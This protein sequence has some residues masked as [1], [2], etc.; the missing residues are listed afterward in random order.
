[1]KT[2][3]AVL[4]LCI[5]SLIPVKAFAIFDGG[6]YVGYSFVGEVARGSTNVSPQGPKI[7]VIAH[8]NMM[9]IPKVLRIGIGA[10]YE[11]SFLYEDLTSKP[12]FNANMVG[13][14]G[15]ICLEII[16]IVKP[17]VRFAPSIW[18]NGKGESQ[19]FNGLQLGGGLGFTIIKLQLY[20]EYLFG[21]PWKMQSYSDARDHSID[22]GIRAWL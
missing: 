13:F 20:L 7:G 14:D 18:E 22:F 12:V 21:T 17:F 16:P 5:L 19:F 6:V 1:M 10:F 11:R 4:I 15:F 9:A 8:A 3:Q 2:L